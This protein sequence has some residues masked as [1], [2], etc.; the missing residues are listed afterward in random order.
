MSP[1]PVAASAAA[2]LVLALTVSVLVAGPASAAPIIQEVLYDPA[3]IDAPDVFTE[4]F[5]EPGLP[6]DGWSLVGIN[7]DTGLA[8][9]TVS[10]TGAV[11]PSDGVLV[12][13][14]GTAAAALAGVRDF[15][16]SVDWQN[17]PDAVQLVDAAGTVVDALQYGDAG[18][19][20]AGFGA[21]APDVSGSSLSRDG[22]GT[23]TLDNLAD[24]AAMTPTPGL[25]PQ[26][27]LPGPGPGPGPDPGPRPAV[28][29]PSVLM[30]LGAALGVRALRRV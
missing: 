3:G 9:R 1:R 21:P 24:F 12:V 17:G 20:N 13:A 8:Y 22:L 2:S 4:L 23:N 6:L 11:F 18:P 15:V 16:G 14:T 26:V 30:L 10:L 29:E 19:F 7:G 28:P 25:G 27:V 5:G